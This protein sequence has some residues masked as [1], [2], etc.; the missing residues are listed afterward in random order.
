MVWARVI[1]GGAIGGWASLS[2]RVW[3][4]CPH[5]CHGAQTRVDLTMSTQFLWQGLPSHLGTAYF[6]GNGAQTDMLTAAVHGGVKSILCPH[7]TAK[8]CLNK[9]YSGSHGTGQSWPIAVQMCIFCP[10]KCC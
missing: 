10:G 4:W 2:I 8:S 5:P 7:P 1:A 6:Q 3:T 9:K